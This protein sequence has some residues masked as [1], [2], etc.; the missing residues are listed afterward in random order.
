VMLSLIPTIAGAALLA[1]LQPTEAN[2]SILLFG[3][4]TLL[5]AAHC[6]L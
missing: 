1:T 4:V 3:T 6:D 5:F 2:K